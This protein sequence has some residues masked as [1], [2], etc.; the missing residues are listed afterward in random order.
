MKNILLLIKKDYIRFKNDKAAVILTFLV[1]AILIVI[2]GN[3]FGGSGGTRGKID[4]VVVNESETVVGKYFEDKLDSS[5]ALRPIKEYSDGTGEN[6]VTYRFTAEKA[7]QYVVEGKYPAALI[8]PEEFYTDTSSSLKF[9]FYYDPKNEIEYAMIQGGLQETIMSEM[10]KIM[11]VLMQ[12]QSRTNLGDV[13]GEQFNDDIKDLIGQYFEID[14]DSIQF[15]QTEFDSSFLYSEPDSV[16]QANNVMNNIIN[17]ESEQVVGEE[18]E[19]PGLTRTVGGWAM[20]FLLFTLTGAA[21]SLF[22]EKNEGSLKRLLCM[23]VKRSQILWSKY[24]YTISLGVIQ[25]MVLFIFAWLI[26]DVNIWS[27]FFNLFIVIL[28]SAAA[29]VAFG[30]IVVSFAKSISQAEGISTLLILTMS[31]V[32]GSWFPVALLPD[33]MQTVAKFTLTYWS[34]EAFQNVLWRQSDFSSVAIHVLI[35]LAIAFIVNFWSL[36]RFRQGKV[37]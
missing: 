26:F 35:L 8:M 17:I 31:A 27:N 21:T 16:Q 1:P 34:V 3:I 4:V 37:F 19:N 28:A 12:R 6:K 14:E 9:K 15:F 20:M 7:K 11:P 10:P 33:W 30:M 25:L 5:K 36:I 22:E 13:K 29:A 23:P 18:V 32:G 2:F 24:I